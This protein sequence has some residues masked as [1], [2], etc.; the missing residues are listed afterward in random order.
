MQQF[1]RQIMTFI[2]TI[3][4]FII[5]GLIVLFS[6]GQAT[7]SVSQNDLLKKITNKT[8][9]SIWKILAPTE[10]S[11]FVS[12]G[13]GFFIDETHFVTN[14]HILTKT[15][16]NQKTQDI[17]LYKQDKKIQIK[18]IVSISSVYDLVLLETKQAVKNYLTIFPEDIKFHPYQDTF[19]A[20]H[21][22]EEIINRPLDS[23]TY[24]L[25]ES[26]LHLFLPI[27]QNIFLENLQGSSGSPVLNIKQQIVGITSSRIDNILIAISP[28]ALRQFTLGQVG[29]DCSQFKTASLCLEKDIK[30]FHEQVNNHL[31]TYLPIEML[32]Y[33]L[34]ISYYYKLNLLEF[35][36]QLAFE[37]FSKSASKGYAP[38]LYELGMIYYLGNYTNR[39]TIKAFELWQ[40]AA[41]QGLPQA[42]NRLDYRNMPHIPKYKKTKFLNLSVKEPLSC[43]SIFAEKNK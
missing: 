20:E 9:E 27:K 33:Q 3:K 7:S 26:D 13:T 42:I 34:A 35:N 4:Y 14:L 29:L 41:E 40:L 1:E 36:P 17:Y 22:T 10:T 37:L 18:S 38:S 21:S 2:S 5:L 12:K 19:V 39:N 23:P 25:Q 8:H 28:H 15:I 32:Q 43:E 30:N 31:K 11:T 24:F 16:K 6:L